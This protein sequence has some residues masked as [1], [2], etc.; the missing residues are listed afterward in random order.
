MCPFEVGMLMTV[1]NVTQVQAPL[2]GEANARIFI[3]T[4]FHFPWCLHTLLLGLGWHRHGT[5]SPSRENC[6]GRRLYQS[7]LFAVVRPA[8]M[9]KYYDTPQSSQRNFDKHPKV[10]EWIMLHTCRKYSELNAWHEIVGR[11]TKLFSLKMFLFTVCN[12][13]ASPS[14]EANSRSTARNSRHFIKSKGSLPC[15]Q[16][17]ATGLYPES[18]QSAPISPRTI[19]ILSFHVRLVYFLPIKTVCILLFLFILI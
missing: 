1:R 10:D 3:T 4:Y 2:L 6:R 12:R 13:I 8:E 14:C 18:D 17:T 9:N 7:F 5:R 11:T 15:S 19:L 16:K